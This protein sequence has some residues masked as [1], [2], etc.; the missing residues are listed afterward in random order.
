MQGDG[1]IVNT[2]P[3]HSGGNTWYRIELGSSCPELTTSQ[4]MRLHSGVGNAG[5]MVRAVPASLPGGLGGRMLAAKA[6]C[7]ITAVYPID[8]LAGR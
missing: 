5:D 1:L 4:S 7:P 6:G 2:A 8:S 3:R